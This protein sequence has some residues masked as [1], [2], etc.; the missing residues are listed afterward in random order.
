MAI[1][2]RVEDRLDGEVNFGAW[3]KIM[4]LILQES[5]LWDIVENSTTKPVT[6]PIDA[7]LLAT[8]NNK[9]IKAKITILDDIKDHLIPHVT[10]EKNSYEMWESLTKLYQSTNENR[11]MVLRETLKIIRMTKAENVVTYLTRMTQVRDELGAIGEAIVDSEIVRTTLNGVTKQWDSFV[12][13]I[14]AREN[15]PKWELI[16]YDFVQVETHRG[17]VHGSSSTGNDEENVALVANNNKKFKRGPKGGNKPKS[18][19]KKDIQKFKTFA[20]HKFGHYVGQFPNKKKKQ[21]T[22]SIEVEE[23]STKFDKEF[24]LVVCLSNRAPHSSVCYIDS[25]SSHNMTAVH[26]N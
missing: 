1:G 15:L 8:Y 24:S 3:K 17:Y 7:T 18:D 5:E 12:E 19:G 26:E 23:F 6:I 20:C 4:I 14:V 10:G 2:L 9:S 16:W 21:T 22:N 25:G 13:G 11:K